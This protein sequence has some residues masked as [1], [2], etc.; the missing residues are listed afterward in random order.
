MIEKTK[1]YCHV[2]EAVKQQEVQNAEDT[3]VN[4]RSLNLQN[5]EE[6]FRNRVLVT[7]LPQRHY[8]EI[9]TNHLTKYPLHRELKQSK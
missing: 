1:T 4:S 5:R 7:E 2:Y 9:I 8:T 3:L 6:Y